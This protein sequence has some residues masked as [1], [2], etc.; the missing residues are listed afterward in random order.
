VCLA[1]VINLHLYQ[2][3]DS[4]VKILYPFNSYHL[5]VQHLFDMD[6]FNPYEQNVTILAS[7]GIPFNVSIPVIDEYVHD[8][9]ITAIGYGSQIG[10][11][12]VTLLILFLLTRADKRRSA[13]FGLNV[14]SLLLNIA[15]L[16]CQVLFFTSGFFKV[17]QFF[18]GDFSKVPMSDY[19]T[20]VMAGVWLALLEICIESSLV[21]QTMVICS[22]MPDLQKRLIFG[23]CCLVAIVPVGFRM[24]QMI[25]NS[26]F[27]IA[28][29]SFLPFVW[30]EKANT[31]L[32]TIS[33]CFFSAVF[34][35]KLGYT[36]HRRTRLGIRQFG[37]MQAIFIMGCQ[38][39][40]IPGMVTLKKASVKIMNLANSI[41]TFSAQ[42]S[43]PSCS[44]RLPSRRST[45]KAS[46][47]S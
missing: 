28:G 15:R 37:P 36:I 7:D 39:M 29:K 20:S 3:Q 31:I 34:V 16:L 30:L 40:I 25:E 12:I 41:L 44:S 10:A 9:I 18:S 24:A 33:I 14:S 5:L 46:P 45:R 38:T 22:N 1:L 26:I 23:L 6:N 13:V 11:S 35:A 4:T 42:Q 43:F 8:G 2:L 21:L 27:T 17:Y 47:S 19:A 32:I